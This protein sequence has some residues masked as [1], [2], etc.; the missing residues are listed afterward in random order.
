MRQTAFILAG[1]TAASFALVGCDVQKTAEGNVDM[2]KYEV[3]KTQEGDV[4][5]PKYD[6]TTP[7]VNVTTEKKGKE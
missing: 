6:V 5:L 7:D 4:S 2:P 1:I 3:S